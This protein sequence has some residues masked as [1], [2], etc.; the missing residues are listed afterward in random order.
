[1]TQ[2]ISD[3]NKTCQIKRV[4]IVA[5][6]DITSVCILQ[7]NCTVI[8]D[9]WQASLAQCQNAHTDLVSVS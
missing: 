1:M 8:Y 7:K 9:V 3:M 4:L 5:S 6:I 2:C